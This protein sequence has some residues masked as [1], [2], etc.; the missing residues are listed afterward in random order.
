MGKEC[1]V[2]SPRWEEC[3]CPLLV[4]TP[5]VYGSHIPPQ[6]L[7][8]EHTLAHT[9]TACARTCLYSNHPGY[10]FPC[11]VARFYGTWPRDMVPVTLDPRSHAASLQF[12]RWPMMQR[13]PSN[14]LTLKDAQSTGVQSTL[15]GTVGI[16]GDSKQVSIWV[17]LTKGI[18]QMDPSTGHCLDR[19][20][21]IQKQKK[22]SKER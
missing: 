14:L 17:S 15:P 21:P 16:K 12:H 20:E 7:T 5:P 22:P 18:R 8:H 2:T 1:G 13:G 10:S 4:C 3:H 6:T 19:K 11:Q 9:H